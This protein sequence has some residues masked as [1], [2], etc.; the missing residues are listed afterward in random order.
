[1]FKRIW[2]VCIMAFIVISCAPGMSDLPKLQEKSLSPNEETRIAAVK[3]IGRITD[4]TPAVLPI[5]FSALKSDAS[6]KVRA[7]ASESLKILRFPESVG[8]LMDSLKNDDE[9]AVRKASLEAYYGIIGAD[10]YNVILDALKDDSPIVRSGG[11]FILGK[12]GGDGACKVLRELLKTDPSSEVRLTAATCLGGLQDKDAFDVLKRAALTDGNSEVRI[13]ATVSI[14]AIPG[15]ASEN[16]LIDTL[17]NKELQDAAITSLQKN[18][19]GSNSSKAILNLLDIAKSSPK[20]DSRFVDIF[21]KSKDARVKP[22]LYRAIVDE[23]TDRDTIDAIVKRFKEENDYSIVPRLI[24]DLKNNQSTSEISHICQALG[25]F[26]DPQATPVLLAEL[27]SNLENRSKHKSDACAPKH[28]M[29]ALGEIGDLRAWNYLCEVHCKNPH[30]DNRYEA[31]EA[32]FHLYNNSP[33]K[34]SDPC[35]CK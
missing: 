3:D 10:S 19:L 23:W 29:W 20:V 21:L 17:K 5:L 6:S 27:Q 35:N 34:P 9:P 16:F 15:S 12:I 1:M 18:N 14:G 4:A 24:N 30:K 2:I 31:G 8:P 7:Q 26:R 13:A 33:Q 32:L 22:Y 28:Y 11:A 25:R